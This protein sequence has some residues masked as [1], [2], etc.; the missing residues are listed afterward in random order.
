MADDMQAAKKKVANEVI[1]LRNKTEKC[2]RDAR[3][4]RK[5]EEEVAK[6]KDPASK[7][8]A[9]DLRK[10]LEALGKSYL[11]QTQTTSQR[12]NQVLKTSVPDEKKDWPD[13]QKGMD[14]WYRDLIEKDSGFDIGNDAK[15][16]GDVS[17]EEKRATIIIKG[18]F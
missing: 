11:T 3:D 5:Q 4:L 13:W 6:A 16:T 8:K 10:A 1:L 7:Q 2:C 12:I 15:L 9:I 17:I 14:K 18:K